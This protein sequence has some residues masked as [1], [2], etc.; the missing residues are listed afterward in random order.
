MDASNQIVGF[1]ID[2]AKA[3]C[4]Q[5]QA[6]CTFTNHAF[7]SLIPALKF[8]KYDAVISGMD[9]TPERSK[10]VAF[11]DPYYANSAL[12]I[13]KKGGLQIFR[14]A[15]RQAYRHGKRHHAPEIPAG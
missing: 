14:R 4:K 2:L 15:E 11:T 7:D 3:L 8:K 10:Q 1:D 5:M 12:V 9:I 13:A 6:D